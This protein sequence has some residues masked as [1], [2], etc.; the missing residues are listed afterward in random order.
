MARATVRKELSSQ[1]D[2][3]KRCH[4]DIYNQWFGSAHHFSSFNNQWYRKSIEYM[5]ETMGAKPSKWC[6]G[7]HDS[8]H[9]QVIPPSVIP[10]L[11]S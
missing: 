1:S 11:S 6:G 9:F 5:Q 2:S 3:C 8:P 10:R 4:E 7:C